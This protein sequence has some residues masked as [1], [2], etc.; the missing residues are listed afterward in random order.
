LP[1]EIF[2]SNSSNIALIEFSYFY[3]I[4]LADSSILLFNV[5][6]V[7]LYAA[8]NFSA[9]LVSPLAFAVSHCSF[10]KAACFFNES[11]VLLLFY[12]RVV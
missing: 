4:I 1:L 9:D 7:F 3:L 12:S 6:M 10:Q 5:L 11:N 2:L 8:S